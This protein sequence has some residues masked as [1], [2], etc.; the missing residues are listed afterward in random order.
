MTEYRVC[1][2]RKKEEKPM[3]D[4]YCETLMELAE[5]NRDILVF[6]ADLMNSVGLMPF[7]K[8]YPEQT[9]DCGIQE[10][11]MF[12]V[13]A[14]ASTMGKIPFIHSFGTFASRRIVDQIFMSGGFARTNVRIMGS[15]PGVAAAYNGGTHMALE[16]IGCLRS[17]PEITIIE[18][19]DCAMLRDVVIQTA[20]MHGI[21][22][23]RLNRK[24]VCRI[25][26]PGSTFEI[27]RSAHVRDG[28][29]VTIIASGMMVEEALIAAEKLEKMGYQAAV[30]NMFTIKP[31][32][33]EAIVRSAKETGAIVTAENHNII[34]GLGSAVAEVLV[35]EMPVPMERVGVKDHFGE[36]GSVSYLKEKFGLTSDE[37]VEKARKAIARK[38]GEQ[39]D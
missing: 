21:F 23:I 11:N 34:G 15:D 27:G 24:D 33:R 37:I 38:R 16:D 32:D 4:V 12:G 39:C 14:G 9:F 6:D 26:E 13:A 5:K 18:P 35:E 19:T 25:Y 7:A 22:Y 31:V 8:A 29:D 20:A 30:E 17:I 10:A 1:K 28:K 2:E 3:R 36:V